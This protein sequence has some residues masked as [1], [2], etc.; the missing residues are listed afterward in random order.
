MSLDWL[1]GRQLEAF[2]AAGFEVIGVSAPG[3]HVEALAARG[4]AHVPV[5]SFTRALAP[6]RDLAA[7]PE[8]VSV[9][10]RLRPDIVHTHNPKPG[11]LGRPAARWAGVP[12][13]VN[14]V[15]GLYAL[16]GDSRRRRAVVY[17]LERAAARFSDVELLQN[18]EDL[19]VMRRLG[20]D[21]ER[22]VVLGNGIDLTRFDPKRVDPRR[23]EALRRQWGAEPGTV[24]V[25]VV[26]R[27]VWEKGYREVFEMARRLGPRARVVVVGPAEPD[28]R[29]AVDTASME[30]AAADGVVFCG[31]RHDMVDVHAAFDVF[32]LASHREGYPRAAMEASA[33]ARPVVATDIRGCRQVVVDGETGRLVPVGDVAALTAAVADLVD[34]PRRRQEWGRAARRRAEAEF[35]ERRVIA[36]TLGVYERLLASAPRRAATTAA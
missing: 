36:I 12:H 24:V 9:F 11:I 16:P 21:D 28:K 25:G 7:G 18:V 26:G 35:D 27:L 3:L 31:E 5:S 33:L 6:H 22:L 19:A 17:G 2:A 15:H 13:V 34:D 14:T 20:V 30:A 1:L 8:L 29:G 4:I 10:R 32:V 23:R